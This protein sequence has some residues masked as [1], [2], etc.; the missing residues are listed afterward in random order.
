MVPIIFGP[1]LLL[2]NRIHLPLCLISLPKSEKNSLSAVAE[3]L[4]K[5]ISGRF[6]DGN[7]TMAHPEDSRTSSQT[8]ISD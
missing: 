5:K 3:S 2:P 7:F 8:K 4:I 6:P 1:R